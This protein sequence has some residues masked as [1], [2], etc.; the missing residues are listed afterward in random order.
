MKHLFRILLCLSISAAGCGTSSDGNSTSGTDSDTPGDAGDDSSADSDS[1]SQS[2]ID[3]DQTGE[4]GVQP[5]DLEDPPDSAVYLDPGNAGDTQQDGSLEHPYESFDNVKITQDTVY[6]V[7]RGSTMQMGELIMTSGITIMSYGDGDERP[8]L[9]S[10]VAPEEGTNQ[11]AVVSGWTGISDV[12]IQD[13]VVECP[14]ATSCIRFGGNDLNN[15]NLNIIN[16]KTEGGTWGIR[17]FGTDGL[18][19]LNTEVSQTYD[20]G[21]FLQRNQNIEIGNCYVHEVNLNWQPPST[22]ETEAGGDAIQ[23]SY[24]NDWHVH[25]NV[26][27]RSDS[28]NK[29]C[30]ISNNGD[31][32][33]GIVEYNVM[34]GP[35][36]VNGGSSIYFHDGDGLI[37]RY[38]TF[39]APASFA[40][41]SHA[42]NLEIYG[43][44]IVGTEGT[45]YT[46]ASSRVYNNTFYQVGQGLRGGEI[47]ARNN[48]FVMQDGA[49]PF[50]GVSN[51]T[52]SHNLIVNA[53]AP[54]GS[55]TGEPRFND[56]DEND[57]SLKETSDAIDVGTD[58]GLSFDIVGVSIPQGS[59][60]DVGA[61]EHPAS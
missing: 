49:V 11:H 22:P 45:L 53:E 52:Q 55:F 15:S 51:L 6:A 9:H 10:T 47:E 44:V 19:I 32:D 35:L 56:P 31:Q 54:E 28:G 57:F 36:T 61:F 5:E 3:T 59:A 34:A 8:V 23:F 7:R 25:H 42:S 4:A 30:F 17:A 43:N 39:L 16:V 14:D 27:D 13:V 37:V 24:C 58:M 2:P 18:S 12:T 40:L 20:D 50:A 46:S 21:M 29:F 60:P 38:N 41:Y 33:N 48:I 26:L 1:G